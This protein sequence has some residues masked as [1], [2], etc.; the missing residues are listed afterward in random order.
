[1]E[2]VRT[3]RPGIAVSHH[4]SVLGRWLGQR[5]GSAGLDGHHVGGDGTDSVADATSERLDD[6]Y[7]P[8]VRGQQKYKIRKTSGV[9]GHTGRWPPVRCHKLR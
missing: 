9:G 7:K 2:P 1:L 4:C 5:R 8:S 3:C 6:A